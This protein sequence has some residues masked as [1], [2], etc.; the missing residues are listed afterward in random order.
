VQ[1]PYSRTQQQRDIVI[2]PAALCSA[3]PCLRSGAA[4]ADDGTVM[5][6]EGRSPQALERLASGWTGK[7]FLGDAT[8]W[9]GPT[10]L[11]NYRAWR[12]LCATWDRITMTVLAVGSN[13]SITVRQQMLVRHYSLTSNRRPQKFGQQQGPRRIPGAQQRRTLQA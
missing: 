7:E 4:T 11:L 1:K 9:A 5:E 6:S 12:C 3:D 8:E 13:D 10:D 2:L